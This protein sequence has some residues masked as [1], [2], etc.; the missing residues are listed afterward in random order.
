MGRDW[1]SGRPGLAARGNMAGGGGDPVRVVVV[2]GEGPG[3]AARAEDGHH[4]RDR[5]DPG[6]AGPLRRGYRGGWLVRP[7]HAGRDIVVHPAVRAGRVLRLRR[8][9]PRPAGAWPGRAGR[10][11]ERQL[12]RHG[13]AGTGRAFQ[14]RCGT[15]GPR[16]P[17]RRNWRCRRGGPGSR[18]A[19]LRRRGLGLRLYGTWLKPDHVRLPKVKLPEVRLPGGRFSF[20]EHHLRR[21]G[22][23]LRRLRLRCPGRGLRLPGR[24]L[25]R[26]EP[27]PG[28]LGRHGA[29]LGRHRLGLPGRRLRQHGRGQAGVVV[30]H[31]ADEVGERPAAVVEGGGRTNGY[32]LAR[33][34]QRQVLPTGLTK[35]F[36][37]SAGMTLG[38]ADPDVFPTFR[39]GLH[40]GDDGMPQAASR[41]RVPLSLTAPPVDRC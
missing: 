39:A 38:A 11:R 12:E 30:I 21:A 34:D 18:R 35:L 36:T 5:D 9:A 20:P 32:G 7:G 29:G 15:G 41:H 27:G 13:G 16:W 24:R 4:H 33:F 23:R 3:G 6:T 17:G 1:P 28:W 37:G 19:R 2:Q 31:A 25:D 22:L 14:L 10:Q 26:A 8:R 40:P